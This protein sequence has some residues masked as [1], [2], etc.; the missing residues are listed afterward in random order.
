[1]SVHSLDHILKGQ[2]AW[3]EYIRG[4]AWALTE[5]NHTLAGWE[6]VLA[7][8]IPIA[9]GLSS[10]A[11]LE[12]ATAC[13]FATLSEW[14]WDP[15]QMA[16]LGQR[17]ENEWL[18][19]RIGIMD[20]MASAC[21]QTDHALLIDCRSLEITPVHRFKQIGNAAGMGAKQMLISAERRRAATQFA[22]RVEYIELT[23]YPGF[24]DRFA[25]AMYF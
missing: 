16:K 1:V 18:G 15:K 24:T 17:A 14:I 4:V 10:S 7:S 25:G 22:Q 9:S 20:Q 11:A 8:D 6:G 12:L 2:P 3:G 19:V 21:G 23:T 13:A 5:T